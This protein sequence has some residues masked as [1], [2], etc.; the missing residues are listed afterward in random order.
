VSRGREYASREQLVET[1]KERFRSIRELGGGAGGGDRRGAS[2]PST[3]RYRL[4]DRATEKLSG[5]RGPLRVVEA[6]AWGAFS[7]AAAS[8]SPSAQAVGEDHSSELVAADDLQVGPV[9]F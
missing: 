8:R 4:A 6:T 9:R 2:T 7:T 5:I 3:R 1:I